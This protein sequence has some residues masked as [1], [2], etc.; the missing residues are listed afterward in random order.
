[1]VNAIGASSAYQQPSS[2]SSAAGL[3]AQLVCYEKQLSDSTCCPSSKT[4]AG[5]Q[6]IQEISSRISEVRARITQIENS[7]PPSQQAVP[8]SAEVSAVA[9]DAN[10]NRVAA[11]V[12]RTGSIIDIQA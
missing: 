9:T 7:K 6:K 12:E 1:M 5:Q 2:G 3:Q 11:G 8:P 4:Q 10:K